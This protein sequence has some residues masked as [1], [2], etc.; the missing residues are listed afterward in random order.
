[1]QNYSGGGWT[2]DWFKHWERAVFYLNRGPADHLFLGIYPLTARPSLANVLMA[3]WL[4]LTQINF[5]HYQ[6]FSALC[7]CL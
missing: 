2:S 1:M 4:Q 5:A 6:L 7:A 3:G